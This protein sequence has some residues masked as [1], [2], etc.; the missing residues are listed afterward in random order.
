M[1]VLSTYVGYAVTIIPRIY[2]Q[3]ISCV[4][5]ALFGVKMLYEGWNMSPDEA[6]EE[7]EEVELHLL[8]FLDLAYILLHSNTPDLG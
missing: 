7:F 1:T 2:T 8:Q 5:F 3:Y 6:Q 4:L